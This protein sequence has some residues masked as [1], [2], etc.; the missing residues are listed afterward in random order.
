MK[1]LD[2]QNCLESNGQAS[3][4]LLDFRNSNLLKNTQLPPQ[5]ATKCPIQQYLLDD[6]LKEQV[7]AK[8]PHTGMVVTITETGNRDE[9]VTRYLSKYGYTNIKALQFG[10]R[11][12]LKKRYPTAN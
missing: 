11:G 9:F 4:T 10:M 2:N 5:I 7:R 6:I 3:L 1:E 8:I 12:W